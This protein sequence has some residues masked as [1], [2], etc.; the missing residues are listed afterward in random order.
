MKKVIMFIYSIVAYLIAFASIVYWILSMSNLVPEI[1][2]DQKPNVSFTMALLNNMALI[3]F[4]GVQHSVMARPGF[5]AIFTRYFP[6]PIE[7]S[8]FVLVSGL[9]LGLMVFQWE[10]MGGLIWSIETYSPLYYLMYVLFFLGWII[11]FVSTFLINHFDLF[12]IRQTY[13]ELI[14]RPYTNL[15]FKIK[16][17]YKYMRHPLYFGMLLGMWATTTMT[18]THLVFAIVITVYVIVGTWFEERDLVRDFGEQYKIY[19]QKKPKFIPFTKLKTIK[20]RSTFLCCLMLIFSV[21]GIGQTDNIFTRDAEGVSRVHHERIPTAFGN[22]K[23]VSVERPYVEGIKPTVKFEFIRPLEREI[24]AF[25][26]KSHS[27]YDNTENATYRIIFKKQHS[28][29][30]VSFNNDGI[31]LRSTEIYK[32]VNLPLK[33]KLRILKTY[34]GFTISANRVRVVYDRHSG[35]SILYKVTID[36]GQYKRTLKFNH[37]HVSI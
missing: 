31:I 10:P 8:T 4:F 6:K 20:S 19:Q 14:G 33:L 28:K 37:D 23:G 12:G 13:L 21:K 17:L 1:S 15:Q 36:N 24:K 2:I 29:A 25:D 27:V 32:D 7:R 30:L 35:I 18:I 3:A 11:L 34:S 22:G 16:S 5:K 9:L 26:V